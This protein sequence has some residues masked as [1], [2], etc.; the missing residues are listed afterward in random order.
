MAVQRQEIAD[1]VHSAAL[2]LVRAVR[3]VD[4]AMGLSPA[5][6]SALSILVFGGPRTVGALAR[7]EGVR[8]PTMTAMVN[9]MEAERLVR[10]RPGFGDG[11]Q[12]VVEATPKGRRILEQ[13]R[14]LRVRRLQDLLSNLD[15]SEL[16]VLDQAAL[17]IDAAVDGELRRATGELNP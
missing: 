6:S 8:S 15:D 13:G 17:L 9:G 10:R 11:R 7:A 4:A 5:R 2:H 12:V 16:A 14:R 3:T 1:R